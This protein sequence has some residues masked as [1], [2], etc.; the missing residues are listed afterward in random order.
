MDA[1]LH[2][3]SKKTL[4]NDV[5]DRPASQQRHSG[6]TVELPRIA[7]AQEFNM[8]LYTFTGAE[9]LVRVLRRATPANAR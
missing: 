8:E 1:A 3:D 4:A 2:T 5:H 7:A 9:C 6:G